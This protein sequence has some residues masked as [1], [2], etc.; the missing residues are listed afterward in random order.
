MTWKPIDFQGI[1]SLNQ[2]VVGQLHQYLEEKESQTGFK[3]LNSIQSNSGEAANPSLS[4]T[5][6]VRIRLSEAVDGLSKKIRQLIQSKQKITNPEDWRIAAKKDNDAIW[7]YLEILEECITELFQQLEQIGVQDWNAELAHVVDTIKEMLMHQLDDLHWCIMRIENQLHEYRWASEAQEGRWVTLRKVVLFWQTALDRSLLSNVDKCQKY[8]GFRYQNFADRYERNRDFQTKIEQSLDKFNAYKVFGELEPETQEKFKKIYQL[9]KFWELNAKA[10]SLPQREAIRSLRN[11]INPDKALSL[12]REYYGELKKTLFQGSRE[13]KEYAA[14][15]NE[16][17]VLKTFNES[18]N[19]YRSELHTL[20]AI[21]AKYREFLL[22][23]DPNPYVRSRWG[24]PEW[25]VGPE[26]S[27]TR[28]MLA[29]GY[30]VEDLSSSFESFR[31]AVEKQAAEPEKPM[32]DTKNEIQNILHEMGQPL[33]SKPMMKLRAEHLVQLLQELDELSSTNKDVVDFVGQA[34]AKGLRVDWK[35]HVLFDQPAFHHIYA[36][37]HDLVGSVDERNHLNRMHKFKRL[38]QQIE[39]WVK[40]NDTPRHTH[41]I[42]LDMNDMK[43]YLQDFLGQVQRVC[44]EQGDKSHAR[45]A[46]NEIER[47]LLEYRYLF[48]NFFHHLRDSKP[49][50]RMIRNQ[51]LFVDQYFEAVENRLHEWK[52]YC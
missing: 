8:L 39:Q 51:F 10:K 11:L 7:G 29:L 47:E 9:V 37:H 13:I 42:E 46:V 33:M 16:I 52:A 4:P 12:F 36:I 35:Y 50:E 41:E 45:P 2:T 31:Q 34:L 22:R 38:I 19:G 30:D 40:D 24:F 27:Q 17:P 43:G 26:S 3:I 18:I 44:G 32:E 20:G 5:S 14:V 15:I 6:D 49:E 48:G 21:I 25:V 1:V 23:T 28:Q